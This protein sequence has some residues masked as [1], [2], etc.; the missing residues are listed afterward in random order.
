MNGQE[1]GK[2]MHGGFGDEKMA[3]EMML[4]KYLSEEQQKDLLVRSL[5]LKIKKKELKISM[6]RD[7][8]RLM[9]EKLDI[10]RVAKEMLR[11]SR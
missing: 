8:I 10:L 7:K 5:D 11:G 4:W 3:M 1:W 6:M 9:E 2:G